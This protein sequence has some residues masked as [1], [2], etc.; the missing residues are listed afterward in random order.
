MSPSSMEPC[1]C[2][3][4]ATNRASRLR[5]DVRRQSRSRSRTSLEAGRFAVRKP[6]SEETLA[7][8]RS[9]RGARAPWPRPYVP[10]GSKRAGRRSPVVGCRERQVKG[11]DFDVKK[12]ARGE[13]YWGPIEAAKK[14]TPREARQGLRQGR[15][16]PSRH[17]GGK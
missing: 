8:P 4:A 1:I 14:P 10:F 6:S 9:I 17:Q 12:T 16:G 2:G 5:S 13:W 3:S 15:Q 7:R 11:T